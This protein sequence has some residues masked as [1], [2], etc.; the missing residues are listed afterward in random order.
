MSDLLLKFVQGFRITLQGRKCRVCWVIWLN[1]NCVKRTIICPVKDLTKAT[2]DFCTNDETAGIS[3]PVPSS[4]SEHGSGQRV[5][6]AALRQHL[7]CD[8]N[9]SDNIEQSYF[10]PALAFGI[11][12]R[13]IAATTLTLRSGS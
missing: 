5:P 1:L 4:L 10:R 7:G 11:H 2:V 6:C 3:F 9:Q 12:L 8:T 13:S